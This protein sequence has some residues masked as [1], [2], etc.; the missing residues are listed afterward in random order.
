MTDAFDGMD[1]KLAYEIAGGYVEADDKTFEQ[2]LDLVRKD[3]ARFAEELQKAREAQR[4]FA[5]KQEKE[6]AISANHEDVLKNASFM[7]SEFANEQFKSEFFADSEIIEA[8]R[9]TPVYDI[10]PETQQRF[11]LDGDEKHAHFEMLYEKAKLDTWR[12]QVGN[13]DFSNLSP[14]NKKK[15]LFASVKSSFLGTLAH[16]RTS[17]QIENEVPQAAEAVKSDNRN[18]FAKQAASMLAKVQKAISF[19]KEVKISS[20]SVMAACAESEAKTNN[21]AKRIAAL[22]QKASGKAKENLSKASILTHKLKNEFVAKAKLVWG[23]RYE[24]MANIRDRAPK[25]A[26]DLAATGVL[27]GATA[28]SAPWLGTAVV[29]YGA[30]KAASAWVWPIVTH[31]R[32]AQRLAKNDE[33]TPKMSFFKRLKQS[34]NQVVGTKDY[35]KEAGWGCAAG[36]LGL[37]A[38]GATASVGANVLLQKSVQSLSSSAVYTANSVTNA[39][40]KLREKDGNWWGKGLAV[41][42]TVVMSYVLVSCGENADHIATTTNGGSIL[43]ADSS[44]VLTNED[45]NSLHLP[46]QNVA[47]ASHEASSVAQEVSASITVP[48]NWDADMGI[49]EA[50][51]TRLQSFWGG[52]A[53]YNSFYQKIT[54]DMLKDGGIFAG[55]T[56]EQVLFEYERLSSWNL[57]Q[58][59][60]VITRMDSFFGCDGEARTMLTTEDTKFLNDVLPSGAIRDVDGS[61]CVRTISREV[62]CGE[63]AIRHDVKVD[64]GC[65]ENIVVNEQAE[66]LQETET[67]SNEEQPVDYTFHNQ[68]GTTKVINVEQTQVVEADPNVKVVQANNLQPG[69]VL[70]QTSPDAINGVKANNIDVVVGE[71]N[72]DIASSAN[73]AADNVVADN[74]SINSDNIEF[75]E[76]PGQTIYVDNA[77]QQTASNVNDVTITRVSEVESNASDVTI[78]TVADSSVVDEN[79]SA[80]VQDQAVADPTDNSSVNEATITNAGEVHEAIIPNSDEVEIGTPAADNVPERGGYMNTGLTEKQYHRM[81]TFFK[82]KFGENAFED[83]M[84]R[85]TDDMRAKG[86]M[87]EGLSKAQALYSVQQMT[88]WSNDQHGAFAQEITTVIEYLKGECKDTITLT[89]SAQIKEIIDKVNENGT[90]DGVTGTTNKMVKFFQAHDC[91]EAGTYNVQDVAGNAHTT[92]PSGPKFPRFFKKIWNTAPEPVFT[93]LEGTTQVIEVVH[94]E[95]HVVD[96]QVVVVQANNLQPGKVLGET[97]ADAVSNVQADNVEVVVG[98]SSASPIEENAQETASA[99]LTETAKTSLQK[100]GVNTEN[101]NQRL[102]YWANKTRGKD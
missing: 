68:P 4:S 46:G 70:G 11:E 99:E 13:E 96:P 56:R 89:E 47:A 50:Q 39:V 43:P 27:V 44:Q 8:E 42:S 65:D 69:K 37:G 86:G 61:E 28:L 33:N 53:Q 24:F 77:A 79:V 74:V 14:D 91:G 59:Q 5:Q 15:S 6:E 58:H 71:G 90:I 36:L 83:Y 52:E 93:E 20:S 41:A 98:L 64:C 23:Q 85:I 80:S 95:E 102:I 19:D 3:D 1:L 84:D 78:T 38:V 73:N 22:A 31:A 57:P 51:W 75:E 40:K 87:F 67:V 60:E 35:Y 49:T 54:D 25:I 81:E 26:T 63:E 101:L 62:N 17:A 45:V 9:N 32:K 66:T 16:L 82:D 30:Y 76:L 72:A 18:F 97:T 94:T 34:A 92:N 88:A 2:A 10:N 55:K 48:E 12:E 29:A 21:F 7:Q 100:Q